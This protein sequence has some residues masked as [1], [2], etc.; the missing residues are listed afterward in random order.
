[1]VH[2]NYMNIYETAL[3]SYSLV[4]DNQAQPQI[5]EK[6]TQFQGKT[7]CL[8]QC[9]TRENVIKAELITRVLRVNPPQYDFWT[10]R[11][12][13]C[14]VPCSLLL[15]DPQ[16]VQ[17]EAFSFFQS[18]FDY[19]SVCQYLELTKEL[20]A[21]L[22]RSLY[23]PHKGLQIK[24]RQTER[25]AK[26]LLTERIKLIP[27]DNLQAKDAM[28]SMRFHKEEA[29]KQ[30]K[31]DEEA[32][33]ARR[34]WQEQKLAEQRDYAARNAAADNGELERMFRSSGR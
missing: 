17:F 15:E 12:K 18:Q 1:M 3:R 7:F 8:I 20:L 11:R 21:R 30:R 31:K 26:Y 14:D 22:E 19:N 5:M 29:E 6:F 27:L 23:Y 25:E 13:D 10:R 33:L 16:G 28:D 2:Y 24:Y 34:R 32:E 9:I 4:S